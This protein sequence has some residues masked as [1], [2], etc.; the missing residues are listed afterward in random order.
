[1][2]LENTIMTAQTTHS[3]MGT[4][5]THRVF[6]EYAEECLAAVCEEVRHLEGLLSRFLSESEIS[7]INRSAGIE[8]EPVSF[9]TYQVLAKAVEFSRNC[10][11][12]F[13]VTIAPLV[14]LWHIARETLAQPPE[15]AIQQALPL[16][17]YRALVLDPGQMTAGLRHAGQSIDLGGIGKGYAGDRILEVFKQYGVL[18]AYSN[19]G[20]NVVT[21]GAKPDGTP[22]RVG[23]QHPRLADR[24]IGS[25][26]VSGKA[27]V[28]SG[29][30]QRGFTDRHGMSH[31]HLLSPATGHPARSGL[32]SVSIVSGS[33]TVADALATAVF[34]AGMAQGLELLRGFPHAEAIL[35]DNDLRVF[36]TRGLQ[37][38]FQPDDGIRPSIVD[39]RRP[40]L[41]HEREA[42]VP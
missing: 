4:V 2:I 21:F 5:M 30:Y 23:I 35:V 18:S 26:A 28:T 1:M 22:W 3:A 7:R 20:G 12:R 36:V 15:S 42:D 9:S 16:V 10:P 25:V 38:H 37:N 14:A 17:D 19:L 41:Q 34:V 32:V 24:L 6:G 27:V 40:A 13:D 8:S 29:D 33:S 31:H 39:L 11:G